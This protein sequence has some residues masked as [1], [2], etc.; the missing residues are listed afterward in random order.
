VREKAWKI[1]SLTREA[2]VRDITAHEELRKRLGVIKDLNNTILNPTTIFLCIRRIKPFSNMIA[3]AEAQ[4]T[5]F[6]N[7]LKLTITDNP[8]SEGYSA[9]TVVKHPPCKASPLN[10]I[11]LSSITLDTCWILVMVEKVSILF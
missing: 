5:S 1:E 11:L 2:A 8:F 4:A 3:Q 9:K 7:E 6:I 10:P